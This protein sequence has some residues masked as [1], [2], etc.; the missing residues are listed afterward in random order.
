MWIIRGKL[1]FLI[2]AVTS[3]KYKRTSTY[4]TVATGTRTHRQVSQVVT[5]F[6]RTGYG[7]MR[8]TILASRDRLCV[9]GRVI[10]KKIQNEGAPVSVNEGCRALRKLAKEGQGCSF[11]SR[12][13]SNIYSL[14]WCF[15]ENRHF[16]TNRSIVDKYVLATS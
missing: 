12:C 10:N 4:L 2:E 9:N 1:C 16:K 6:N 7:K 13:V 15:K 5:E 14:M 3:K 11:Y 8:M